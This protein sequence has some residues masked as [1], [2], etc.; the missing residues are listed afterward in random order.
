VSR[1]TLAG[2]DAIGPVDAHFLEAMLSSDIF[3]VGRWLRLKRQKVVVETESSKKDI[4][5]DKIMF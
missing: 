3:W 4:R 1:G 2:G 5:G